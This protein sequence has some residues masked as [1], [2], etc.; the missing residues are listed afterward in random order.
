MIIFDKCKYV[1]DI[2]R[3]GIGANDNNADR[4]LFLVA[5]YLIKETTYKPKNIKE[6]LKKYARE[7]FKGLSDDIVNKEIDIIYNRA[8][9]KIVKEE[10]QGTDTLEDNDCVEE[11]DYVEF[12]KE[13]DYFKPKELT[14]YENE[15]KF[16]S[17]LDKNL[18]ELAF[19]FLVVHKFQGY[20]WVSECNSDIYRICHWNEKGNGK[21]QTTKDSLIH[22]LVEK[23][24][25]SFYCKTNKA[26]SYNKSWIAKTFFTVLINED[27]LK[28][29]KRSPKWKTITNYDDVLLYWKLYQGDKGVKLCEKCG[30]PIT[31]TGN[32]KR[33][34]S[35]CALENIRASKKR[36]KEKSLK[37]AS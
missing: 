9:D 34:C 3:C 10:K 5:R 17:E 16:I 33:F 35:N 18:Q 2:M 26:Y 28:P 22:K 21:S 30:T 6:N 19:A 25:I 14:L 11:I 32:S 31:D 27:N 23:G 1:T 37:V 36:S 24:V 15:M 20:K 12:V 13:M 8:K 7:Y 4:K 29:E